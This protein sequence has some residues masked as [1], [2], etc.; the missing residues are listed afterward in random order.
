MNTSWCFRISNSHKTAFWDSPTWLTL[1]K[2]RTWCVHWA[3][4]FPHTFI[5]S[6]I[7]DES[8]QVGLAKCYWRG[9]CLFLGF[10]LGRGLPSV[11]R[12]HTW[13]REFEQI[14]CVAPDSGA[15]T[16]VVFTVWDW[17]ANKR[18]W[19]LKLQGWLRL[20]DKPIA[21][22]RHSFTTMN[23][24]CPTL[25]LLRVF[26]YFTLWFHWI[27]DFASGTFSSKCTGYSDNT[28]T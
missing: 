16:Y 13:G 28:N 1:S 23:S 19:S 11:Q 8:S 26:W 21:N 24:L 18:P 20:I 9:L 25:R 15:Y 12:A 4:Q 27:T 17:S 7:Q 22:K 14:P 10:P 3:F 6:R 2:S 5:S